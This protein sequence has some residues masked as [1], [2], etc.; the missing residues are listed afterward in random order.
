MGG[1]RASHHPAP[2]LPWP[3]RRGSALMADTRKLERTKHPGIY[4]RHAGSCSANGRCK[5]PYVVRWKDRGQPR[6]QMFPTLDLAREFKGGLDSGKGVR[7]PLSSVTLGAYFPTW[8]ERFR[9]RTSRGL[10]QSSR[11]EDEIS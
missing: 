1:G 3:W 11:R 10:E 2:S 6:K 9:G 4:R 8:L 5:C 7:R